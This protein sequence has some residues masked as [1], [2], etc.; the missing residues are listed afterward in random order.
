MALGLF[1]WRAAVFSRIEGS[2]F[3]SWRKVGD[4]FTRG[5]GYEEDQARGTLWLLCLAADSWRGFLTGR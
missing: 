2:W 1:D 5:L 3:E 4:D